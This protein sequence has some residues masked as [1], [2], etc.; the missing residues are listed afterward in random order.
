MGKN[1]SKFDSLEQLS[2]VRDSLLELEGQI[3]SSMTVAKDQKA[4]NHLD[5]LAF[6]VHVLADSCDKRMQV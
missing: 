4:Y 6:K 5:A 2:K 1:K 3:T